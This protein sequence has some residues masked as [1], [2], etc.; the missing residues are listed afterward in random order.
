MPPIPN[1]LNRFSSATMNQLYHPQN[2][3]DFF[4]FL[5]Q[6]K[7]PTWTVSNN[8]VEDL[9]TRDDRGGKSFVGVDQFLAANGLEGR[10]LRDLAKAHYE[11]P[12]DPPRKPFDYYCAFALTTSMKRYMD[13]VR[14][15]SQKRSMVQTQLVF[16]GT[17]SEN[18]P[19]VEE[20]S[21]TS[22]TVHLESQVPRCLFYSNV[23]GTTFISPH[24]TWEA[25]LT[26]YSSAIKT[27]IKPADSEFE[28]SK[29]TYFSKELE[30]M[31][32]VDYVGCL[33][34]FDL[35]FHLDE[36]TKKLEFAEDG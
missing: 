17:F 12:Y 19:I 8:V 35:S 32:T 25:T 26:A 23:Y 27:D 30:I 33:Q 31:R 4:A 28:K 15:S 21:R 11:S 24:S 22:C 5:A 7:I 6:H 29:K 2:A 1:F 18:A 16:S 9:T 10:F 34:V 13:K 3:A 14:T 36:T 20:S